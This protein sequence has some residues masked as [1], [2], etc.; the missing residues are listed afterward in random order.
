LDDNEDDEDEDED[1]FDYRSKNF[2]SS[3]NM[4]MPEAYR[5]ADARAYSL[6][7]DFD[8]GMDDDYG[9]VDDSTPDGGGP[10]TSSSAQSQQW[11]GQSA[12]TVKAFLI[13][14]LGKSIGSIIHCALLGGIANTL[15]SFLR[16]VEFL[17]AKSPRFALFSRGGGQGQGQGYEYQGVGVENDSTSSSSGNNSNA[18]QNLNWS[19]KMA[20][21]WQRFQIWSREFVRNHHDMGLCHV[22]AY[23]KSYT[24]AA[25]D[26]MALIDASGIE[27]ILHGDV[28][29]HM[30]SSI[31]KSIAGIV[32]I[33]VWPFLPTDSDKRTDITVCEIMVM[34][35]AMCYVLIYT[36]MEPLRASIKAVYVCFAQNQRSLS[37]AFPI[38]YHRLD[39]MSNERNMV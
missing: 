15:W 9:D 16:V 39:R 18:H 22:A 14:G 38:L 21:Y 29:S 6:G 30:C 24:R 35:F 17:I 32:V 33:Y 5:N 3:N 27:P 11:S 13:S 25:N 34:T 10:A 7:I 19:Q 36:M 2:S 4:R 12:S 31:S 37:Q 26:V 1:D 28:S 20:I 23:Y 8:E